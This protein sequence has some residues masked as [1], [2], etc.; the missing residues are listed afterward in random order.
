LKLVAR[1]PTSSSVSTSARSSRFPSPSDA[2]EAVS[3]SSGL[4]KRPTAHHAKR[5]DAR[6]VSAHVA[7]SMKMERPAGVFSGSGIP[8]A[9][10][11]PSGSTRP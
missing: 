8:T 1:E 2:A 9:T 5:L 10:P 7:V 4:V 3:F 6:S 11:H